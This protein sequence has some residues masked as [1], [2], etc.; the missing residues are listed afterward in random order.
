MAAI[1]ELGVLPATPRRIIWHWTGGGS[2]ANDVDRKHYH[3]IIEQDGTIVT[4]RF[5]VASNMQRV[6]GS[7]YAQHT[8]GMN[9]FSVGI[10][11]A[12]MKDCGSAQRPGPCPLNENQV[13]AGLRFTA[14]CCVAWSLDPLNPAHCFHHREAWELHGI[15]GTHNHQKFD[16]TFLPFL[17]QLK[18]NETGPWLRQKTAEFLR[19]PSLVPQPGERRWSRVAGWIV[20]TR[21]VSDQ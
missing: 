13:L 10:S 11:F 4:G 3:W 16:I 19:P 12:G 18:P 6:W 5:L 20:L 14:A 21:Y 17:P 9:S 8:G 2:R 1:P 15:K 7:E